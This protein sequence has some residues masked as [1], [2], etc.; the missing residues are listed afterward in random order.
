MIRRLRKGLGGAQMAS[1]A[2]RTDQLE[3]R[4]GTTWTGTVSERTSRWWGA[5]SALTEMKNL[6]I[7]PIMCLYK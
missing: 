3:K 2:R 6:Y 4:R 1:G 5:T 7:L